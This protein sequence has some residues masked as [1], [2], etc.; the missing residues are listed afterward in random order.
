MSELYIHLR[1]ETAL[2]SSHY[3]FQTM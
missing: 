1:H 3:V 2:M